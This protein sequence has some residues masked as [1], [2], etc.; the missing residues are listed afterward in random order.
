MI[1]FQ[2]YYSNDDV[3]FRPDE[4]QKLR[5][6]Q[7]EFISIKS[8]DDDLIIEDAPVENISVIENKSFDEIK[9]EID[10]HKKLKQ[11]KKNLNKELKSKNKT[12]ILSSKDWD[13][14]NF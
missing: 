1:E 12:G 4:I 9:Q 14:S 2:A 13:A 5:K 3:D 10:V 8:S 6:K 7:N 11:E